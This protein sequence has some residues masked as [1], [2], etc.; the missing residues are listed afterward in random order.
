M[1]IQLTQ[2]RVVNGAV[3]AAGTQHTLAE[4]VEAD[5]ITNGWATRVGA[6]PDQSG[7]GVP[8]MIVDGVLMGPD[9]AVVVND[10]LI[11]AS[12]SWLD[13]QPYGVTSPVRSAGKLVCRFKASEWT[14][15][16]TGSAIS[17]HTGYDAYGVKSGAL[18]AGVGVGPVSITGH[19]TMIKY[20]PVDT[21]NEG[22]YPTTFSTPVK[23]VALNGKFGL[24][25][26][27]EDR[28]DVTI[29]INLST[30]SAHTN[31]LKVD[32][33]GAAFKQGW[34]FLVFVMRN[35]QAYVLGSGVAEYHPDGVTAVCN[36]NGSTSDILNNPIAAIAIVLNGGTIGAPIYF[37]SLWT[38]FDVKSQYLMGFDAMSSSII[39]Y[40]IPY[41]RHKGYVTANF[42]YYDGTSRIQVDHTLPGSNGDTIYAAGW[43]IV[44]HGAMHLPGTASPGMAALTD[45]AEIAYELKSLQAAM[46]ARGW[47]RGQ[48]L[49]VSPNSQTSQLCERVIGDL[50]YPLH[51]HGAANNAIQITPFG[52]PNPRACGGF[53]MGSSS[54]TYRLTTGGVSTR[55]TDL[56]L[57]SKAQAYVDCIIAYGATWMPFSH[58]IET[59]SD[60]G[61][62]NQ[63][64]IDPNLV[65]QSHFNLLMDYLHAKEDAG[66]ITGLDGSDQLWYGVGR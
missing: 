2:A 62:G 12:N 35:P 42:S 51:R 48:H 65:K 56:Y 7:L 32:F 30:T 17:D 16:G 49:Y 11:K 6:A 36:G 59:A 14:L 13:D 31:G 28:V 29:S 24:W 34:N 22:M 26:Y 3:A 27:R 44:N 5:F 46:L 55:P 53:G 58:G 23:T 61:S 41:M 66:L 43:E 37:D 54:M 45:P 1:T 10:R 47:T 4:S 21:A 60:D 57:I 19:P 33:S 50:G 25:V 8:A 63:I 39:D 40:A 15:T 9:G 52:I 64:P 20:V 38:D 18:T